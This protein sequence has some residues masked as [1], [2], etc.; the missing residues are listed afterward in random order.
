VVNIWPVTYTTDTG[1]NTYTLRLG[2]GA[3]DLIVDPESVAVYYIPVSGSFDPITTAEKQRLYR[4]V[5]SQVGT[6]T[7]GDVAVPSRT[8]ISYG[9][10]ARTGALPPL[11]TASTSITP[12]YTCTVPAGAAFQ[13]EFSW[14]AVQP[15]TLSTTSSGVCTVSGYNSGGTVTA[16]AVNTLGTNYNTGPGGAGATA[17]VTVTT[18]PDT[19]IINVTA[20]SSARTNWQGFVKVLNV[21]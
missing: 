1:P 3:D 6:A 12:I 20:E 19:V 5:R 17:P 21:S 2:G 4:K 8:G 16:S 18:G 11:N 14:L 9:A 7:P 15:G 13:I 10:A